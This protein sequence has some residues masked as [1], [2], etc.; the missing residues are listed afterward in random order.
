M[1]KAV[2]VRELDVADL[3]VFGGLGRN[4]EAVTLKKLVDNRL[5]HSPS[6]VDLELHG[7]RRELAESTLIDH[8]FVYVDCI[9]DH[10]SSH[11]RDVEV[12]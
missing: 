3:K 10:R 8:N 11:I 4:R 7:E 5:G 1:Q 12:E 9:H 2:V 6:I